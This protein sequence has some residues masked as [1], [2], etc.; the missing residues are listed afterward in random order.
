M[1]DAGSHAFL[2]DTM[3]APETAGRGVGTRLVATA[4]DHAR[5]VGCTWLHVDF[6]ADLEPFYIGACGFTPTKAGVML[7]G[8]A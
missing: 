6:E 4:A 3:V 7:L 1:S 2:L 5:A 8:D